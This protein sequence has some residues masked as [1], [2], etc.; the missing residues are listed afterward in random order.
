MQRSSDL[1]FL[2]P[3]T[4]TSLHC[5]TMQMGLVHCTMC[6]FTSQL[7]LV[8]TMPAPKNGQAELTLVADYIPK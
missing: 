6:L 4:D 3:L 7:S 2:S 5:Q 8:L 1:H